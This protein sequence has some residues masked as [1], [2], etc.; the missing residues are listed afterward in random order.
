MLQFQFIHVSL[1]FRIV[2][3]LFFVEKKGYGIPWLMA[4][5]V[6]VIRVTVGT[7]VVFCAAARTVQDWLLTNCDK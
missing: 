4:I 2:K 1:Q 7:S 5:K 3:L 6:A